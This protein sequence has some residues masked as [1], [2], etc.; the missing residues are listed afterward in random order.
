MIAKTP[1]VG[2]FPAS[3]GEQIWAV[4]GE[5]PAMW[6]TS[7]MA[8]AVLADG[9][10]TPVAPLPAGEAP[11]VIW[12][13]W[14]SDPVELRGEWAYQ[15]PPLPGM[16]RGTSVPSTPVAKS[17]GIVVIGSVGLGPVL[18]G[19]YT[20]EEGQIAAGIDLLP[21]LDDE[22]ID[23]DRTEARLLATTAINCRVTWVDQSFNDEG[24]HGPMIMLEPAGE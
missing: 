6:Q 9:T 11:R 22:A 7:V 13:P 20:V 24:Q 19:P 10:T 23:P 12:G 17:A 3:P 15:L 18:W 21:Q 8:W 1:I 16:P 4:L 2:T 5:V 14:H